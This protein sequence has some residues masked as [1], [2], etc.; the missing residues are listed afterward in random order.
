MRLFEFDVNENAWKK[1]N[2]SKKNVITLIS[3]AIGARGKV[4]PLDDNKTVAKVIMKRVDFIDMFSGYDSAANTLLNKK[5]E[6]DKFENNIEKSQNVS[7][8]SPSKISELYDELHANEVK[9]I[10]MNKKL[11]AK[12]V[13]NANNFLPNGWII[14]GNGDLDDTTYNSSLGGEI[15]LLIRRDHSDVRPRQEYYY[16][17]TNAKNKKNIDKEGLVPKDGNRL[18]FH[19]YKNRVYLTL[20]P[21]EWEFVNQLFSPSMMGSE[22]ANNIEIVVYKVKLPNGVETYVDDQMKN[23]AVFIRENIPPSNLR[24]MWQG[25]LKDLPESW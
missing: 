25:D 15:N 5:N 13:S 14:E 10:K 3:N 11:F 16:H 21:P 18:A 22:E 8:H 1:G 4:Q 23:K 19:L 20:Q 2:V 12:S 24:I 9:F 6:L 17:A 7:G